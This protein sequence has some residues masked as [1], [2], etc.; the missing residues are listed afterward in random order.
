MPNKDQ[1]IAVIENIPPINEFIILNNKI[2]NK[3]L[4]IIKLFDLIILKKLI[5]FFNKVKVNK[6]NKKKPAEKY[7]SNTEL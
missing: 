7:S 1:K 2:L 5:K 3:N 4:S 6:T